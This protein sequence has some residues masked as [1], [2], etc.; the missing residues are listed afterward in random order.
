MEA[1]YRCG[2]P[3]CRT[4][5]AIDLHH[6]VPTSDDGGD[7]PDNL[8][9]LRPTCHALYHRGVISQEAI[10]NWKGILVTLN[11]A[12]DLETIDKLLFLRKVH[13]SQLLFFSRD[14]VLEFLRLIASGLAAFSV[15]RWEGGSTSYY[16]FPSTQTAPIPPSERDYL[17]RLTQK[18]LM[19]VDAWIKGDRSVVVS[20]LGSESAMVEPVE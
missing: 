1:G 5:L 19:L 6:I 17:V 11:H 15:V 3:V 2:N 13:K 8:I 4:I 9:A 10:R 20:A 18:G 16:D 14:G 7:D 12:F